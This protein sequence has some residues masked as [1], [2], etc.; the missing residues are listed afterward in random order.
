MNALVIASVTQAVISRSSDV[1]WYASFK[2]LVYEITKSHMIIDKR[3]LLSFMI[4][5]SG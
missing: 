5:K 4:E 3:K 2:Q 1:H